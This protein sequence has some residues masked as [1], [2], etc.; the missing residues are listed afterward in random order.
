MTNIK[1]YASKI[2]I[3]ALTVGTIASYIIGDNNGYSRGYNDATPIY[4]IWGDRDGQIA[5]VGNKKKTTYIGVWKAKIFKGDSIEEKIHASLNPF[6]RENLSIT[7]RLYE[8]FNRYANNIKDRI[9]SDEAFAKGDYEYG[10]YLYNLCKQTTTKDT[11]Q[12]TP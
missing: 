2:L 11:T 8:D 3:G 6:Y 12:E 7:K 4:L 10:K 1:K 9:K 5:V